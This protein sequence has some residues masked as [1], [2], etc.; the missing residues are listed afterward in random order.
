LIAVIVTL[1]N[2]KVLKLL[3]NLILAFNQTF[4]LFIPGPD[5]IPERFNDFISL[6]FDAF[7]KLGKFILNDLEVILE[8]LEDTFCLLTDNSID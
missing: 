6:F 3:N 4:K 2:F 1:S 7:L 5:F 8:F